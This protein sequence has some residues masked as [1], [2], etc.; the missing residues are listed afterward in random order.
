MSYRPL[1]LAYPARFRRRH[2]S[3]LLT[4]MAEMGTPS[5]T[6]L[7]HV[8]LDGVRER[9]RLPAGRPLAVLAAVLALLVGGALGAAAGSAAGSLTYADLP[10]PEAVAAVA[11]DPAGT[12]DVRSGGDTDL[13][14]MD[15]LPPGADLKA[16]ADRSRQRLSTAGWAV[17]PVIADSGNVHFQASSATVELDIYAYGLETP[18]LQVTGWP[19]R[20]AAY[21]WLA[22][23]GTLIG[24]LAG[25]L[26][27]AA[28]AHRIANARRR[29]LGAGLALTGLL[30]L[31]PP[32]TMFAMSLGYYL[33]AT[34]TPGPEGMP[35]PGVLAPS[36]SL[37]RSLGLTGSLAVDQTYQLLTFLGLAAIAVAMLLARPGRTAPQ[38][39]IRAA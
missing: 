2:G 34:S 25:W 20:P 11:M 26:L 12:P 8:V 35:A 6:D 13:S 10:K 33:T 18:L 38:A 24:M 5:R 7:W 15:A 16:V 17:G 21:L 28:A 3:E 4:T 23:A 36:L 22:V 32:A 39:D 37:V 29:R 19:T 14:L 31:L 9:F 30:A 1:L 27:A